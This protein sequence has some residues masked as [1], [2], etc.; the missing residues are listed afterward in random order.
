[1]ARSNRCHVGPAIVSILIFCLGVVSLAAQENVRATPSLE[2][3]DRLRDE[4]HWE[5]LIEVSRLIPNPGPDV[6]LLRGLALAR[7]GRLTEAET[8][9]KMALREEGA[10]RSKILIE[11]AGVYFKQKRYK[12][13]RRFLHR[14]MSATP[15]DRYLLDFL[16][17]VYYLEGNL[18]AALKYWNQIDKPYL[19]DVNFNPDDC[20]KPVLLNR[21]L[22][23]SP[24]SELSLQALR[25]TD[26]QLDLLG[27]FSRH[28]YNLAAR[29]DGR[30]DLVIHAVPKT[31]ILSGSTIS[32]ILSAARELPFQT[33]NVDLRNLRRSALNWSSSLRW[34]QGNHRLTSFLT[35]PVGGNPKL[36]YELGFS[37]RD[38]EWNLGSWREPTPLRM[39]LLEAEAGITSILTDRWV[40]STG[41][42]VSH[43]RLSDFV[44]TFPQADDD[45][46]S[47]SVLASRWRT[48]FELLR[49]PER[50]LELTADGRWELGRFWHDQATL[51]TIGQ[52]GIR[53]EWEAQE[54]DELIVSIQARGGKSAGQ[55]PFDRL[56]R[57]GV[58]LD[59]D[60]LLRAHAGTHNG[61]KGNSPMGSGYLLANLDLQKR[62]Y[63]NALLTVSAG[64][65]LDTG[66][67]LQ[68]RSASV[69]P[70]MWDAGIEGR[71]AVLG[72]FQVG[73]SYGID[74]ESGNGVI[75]CRVTR[76]P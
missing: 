1:M 68:P 56:F 13:S 49:F 58:D 19:V 45:F 7:T 72:I 39:R 31:G 62:I 71:L 42:H 33:L 12:E 21:A 51:F 53:A 47:G 18:E 73:V 74:L 11:L 5:R 36:V 15:A 54:N 46:A 30:F 64:P 61:L 44:A 55:L 67:I 14:A 10:D 70:W 43:R 34:K 26:R 38:E 16:G 29:P 17:S 25:L 41:V 37:A 48:H 6:R 52:A 57:L 32:S 3:L 24:A 63:S 65:F 28:R 75:Y 4:E 2:Q 40:W 22:A 50:R 23:V 76:K 8:E 66:K 9:L 35:S 27:V 59:N 60:L 69:R 20:L